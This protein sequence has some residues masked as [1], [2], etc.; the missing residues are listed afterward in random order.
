MEH[1][2]GAGHRPGEREDR[3]AGRMRLYLGAFVLAGV[4]VTGLVVGRAGG[5]AG[6]GGAAPA[7]RATLADAP[8]VDPG[9]ETV[10][11]EPYHC[12]GPVARPASRTEL[13]Q[14]L[15]EVRAEQVAAQEQAS[16]W[17]R[18]KSWDITTGQWVCGFYPVVQ[19]EEAVWASGPEW[20]VYD[21]PDGATIGVAYGI[22]GFLPSEVAAAHPTQADVVAAFGCPGTDR[23]CR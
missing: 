21:A 22:V 17:G 8:S 2:L 5:E 19:A 10:G 3:S 13:E 14:R 4:V 1:P 15:D 7:F 6:E 18:I 12:A 16:G 23:P 20:T 11:P 9:W